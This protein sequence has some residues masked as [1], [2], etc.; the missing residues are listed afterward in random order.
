MEIKKYDNKLLDKL[1]ELLINHEWDN[2]KD[3]FE[4]YKNNIDINQHNKYNNYLIT[5]T[6]IFNKSDLLK[7]LLENDVYIDVIDKDQDHY[8]YNN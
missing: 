7:L 1:F 2:F 6:I 5:Y 4:K 3:L 8:L